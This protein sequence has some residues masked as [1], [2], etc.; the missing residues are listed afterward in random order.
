[1]DGVDYG[2][3]RVI[4]TIN[5]NSEELSLESHKWKKPPAGIAY[6]AR[7]IA[8]EEVR[9]YAC[10]ASIVCA[11]QIRLHPW[12]TRYVAFDNSWSLTD[13]QIKKL[14]KIA[15]DVLLRTTWVYIMYYRLSLSGK[16][17][18]DNMVRAIVKG[19]GVLIRE[20]LKEYPMDQHSFYVQE[21]VAG[22]KDYFMS[23][24]FASVCVRTKI[25]AAN[26][27]IWVAHTLTG[28]EQ[29]Y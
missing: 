6:I 7:Y 15:N 29:N 24:V 17:E 13:N 9:E 23:T 12:D 20:H 16:A 14:A 5:Q 4:E 26:Q 3:K 2:A 1:L 11:D 25:Y 8:Q 21:G 27:G 18:V 22:T 19:A 10:N 28:E